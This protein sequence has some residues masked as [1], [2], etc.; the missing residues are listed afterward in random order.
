MAATAA[1]EAAQAAEAA[2]VVVAPE[3]AIPMM[4]AQAV[5]EHGSSVFGGLI[6]AFSVLLIIIS[7]IVVAAGKTSG[8]KNAGYLFFAFSLGL[9]A[10]GGYLITREKKA[11]AA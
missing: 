4:A 9:A 1:A 11:K 7:I 2:G 10:F 8:A 5:S 6:M 3:V